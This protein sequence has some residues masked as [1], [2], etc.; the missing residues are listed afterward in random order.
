MCGHG[1]GWTLEC[2][3]PHPYLFKFASNYPCPCPYPTMRV[4]T[5]PSWVFFAGAHCPIAIPVQLLL[6]CECMSSCATSDNSN[7]GLTTWGNLP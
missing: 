3:Y 7:T 4:F 1:A 5:R 6:L 2:P